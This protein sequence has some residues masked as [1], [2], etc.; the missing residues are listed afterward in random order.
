[1][2]V[3][4]LFLI[5]HVESEKNVLPQFSHGDGKEPVTPNGIRQG[6]ALAD[7]MRT[8]LRSGGVQTGRSVALHTADTLR[9]DACARLISQRL[10]CPKY[11]HTELRPIS[12]G[13]LAG[14]SEEEA[15]VLAP[16][17]T[18]AL[19]LYRAGVLSSYQIP[20]Y[21]ESVIAFEQ[22]VSKCIDGICGR[23]EPVQIVVAHRSPITATLIRYA[24]VGL[25]YPSGFYGHIPLDVASVSGL[26][27]QGA[28]IQWLG[29][30]LR[31]EELAARIEPAMVSIARE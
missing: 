21:G 4:L 3:K 5:R 15:R 2:A 26:V 14:L 28:S 1:M 24:R 12:S 23:A 29:V 25:G 6:E 11:E 13:R 20:G 7:A 10:G 17:F 8:L 27:L 31:T 9:S 30:N 16:D 22:R 18:Q 19:E